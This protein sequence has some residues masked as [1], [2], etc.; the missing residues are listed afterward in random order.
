MTF[1][2]LFPNSTCPLNCTG[3]LSLIARLVPI[4][5]LFGGVKSMSFHASIWR[6][7]AVKPS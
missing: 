1:I 6:T 7:A 5:W 3:L 2:L 4:E